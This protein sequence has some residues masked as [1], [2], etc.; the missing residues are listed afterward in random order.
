MK[1]S[2]LIAVA[3]LSATTGFAQSSAKLKV[4]KLPE[5]PTL[6]RP[7]TAI[8]ADL[9]KSSVRR[10][11]N[12]NNYYSHPEGTFYRGYGLDG[13]GYYWSVLEAPLSKNVT[14]TEAGTATPTWKRNGQIITDASG[15]SYTTSLDLAGSYGMEPA[16]IVVS[17]TDSFGIGTNNIYAMDLRLNNGTRTDF[18]SWLTT[19]PEYA[20]YANWGF[21]YADSIGTLRTVDDHAGYL[22]NSGR[23]TT[24]YS[25]AQGWGSLSTDNMYGS[26]YITYTKEQTGLD[27][28]T[29]GDCYGVDVVLGKTLAPLYIERI[30]VKGY[31]TTQPIKNN[32]RL[33]AY[34]TGVRTARDGS[35]RADLSKVYETLYAEATD[36]LDFVTSTQ[37]NGITVYRG[38]VLFSKRGDDGF[39][40]ITDQPF[41]LPA[42]SSYAVFVTGFEDTQNIDFGPQALLQPDEENAEPSHFYTT[43]RGSDSGYVH[44]YQGCVADL[45]LIGMYDVAFA[46][47]QNGLFT[48]DDNTKAN[49]VRISN[50]GTA[51]ATDGATESGFA[52]AVVYTTIPWYDEAGNE[53]YTIDNLP[54]WI[55]NYT[56]GTER[57]RNSRG[58]STS[59]DFNF[60]VI[61][62]NANALPSGTAGRGAI[63]TVKSDKGAQSGPI[64]LLQGNATVADAIATGINS[65]KVD[66]VKKATDNR[67]FNLAG[68]QVT[69][70]YKG[71]VIENGKKYIQK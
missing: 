33:T 10:S 65:V 64:Y 62:F 38:T 67:I 63:V 39:G 35:K 51:C 47:E 16:P 68:Q 49:V 57:Y 20:S 70:A 43:L 6:F 4:E 7:M 5:L 55:S 44:Y 45:A 71:I 11:K 25:N 52:G 58:Q 17:R 18:G 34:V 32:A 36:T 48:Q 61:S 15:N 28:D 42:D 2:L 66:D 23:T 19:Y 26:G 59:A 41:V 40:N 8:N 3:L 13:S 31:T 29:I 56:V 27:K 54:D 22:Y 50:D 1:K 69:K 60:Y 21:L 9:Q 53:N 37:R 14:F 46:P 12:S 30:A 24:L